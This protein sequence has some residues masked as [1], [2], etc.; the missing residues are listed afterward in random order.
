MINRISRL[1][2][3][4]VTLA[5]LSS[6]GFAQSEPKYK[7]LP[8][9]HR[10][11]DKLYR[12]GQPVIGGVK[13]LSELGIKTVVNL[14][15]EDENTR[16]EQKEVEAAGLR[17]FSIALPG[18]SRPTDEQIERVME[19]LDAPENGPVFVHCKRGSDRTG[20]VV[21]IYRIKHENWTA[22]RA[23]SEAK[24]YGMSWMEFGMKDYISD[25]YVHHGPGSERQAAKEK[26]EQ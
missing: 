23:K 24:K 26:I 4:A 14:R 5:I 8:N 10:V 21:A 18:L 17:Y 9:F 19:V 20:T 12:G 7:E 11:S 25:Y 3:L 22:E 2:V 6:A 16:A 1:S 13:K 15:G